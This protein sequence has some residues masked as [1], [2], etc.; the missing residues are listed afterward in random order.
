[1]QIL[2]ILPPRIEIPNAPEQRLILSDITWEQYVNFI[3]GFVDKYPSL[4]VT[5]LE[6]ILEIMSTSSEHERLK[7]II[8]RLLE[9]YAVEKNIDLNG[10][11]NTTFRDQ[12]ALRGLEPDECYCFGELR[13]V[14]DIALEIVISSGGINKLK[15]YEGL[16]IPEVWF[17]QVKNQEWQLYRLQDREYQVCP[18]SQFLPD[19]DLELLGQFI[20]IQNQT[21]AVIAYRESL[22]TNKLS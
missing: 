3:D 12:S 17:W 9:M 13:A 19:L 16:Q 8:A 15:V 2:D 10:Y 4:R 1:M 11:G 7:K 14:P 6:G 5:Y 18:R 20:P 22:K 21:Q